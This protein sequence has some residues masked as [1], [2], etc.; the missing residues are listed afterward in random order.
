MSWFLLRTKTGSETLAQGELAKQ[1]YH[2]YLPQYSQRVRRNGRRMRVVLPLFPRYLFL[3]LMVGQ[4]CLSPVRSTKGVVSIVRFG[5]EYAQVPEFVILALTRRADPHGYHQRAEQMLKPSDRVRV[6]EGPFAQWEGI[7]LE[8]SGEN[9][10]RILLN[11][12]GNDTPV[13]LD[14]HIVRAVA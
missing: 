9:R 6:S 4:Q 11:L 10:V 13:E 14:E 8:E 2:S 7:F 5:D 12:L 1:N 3:Q